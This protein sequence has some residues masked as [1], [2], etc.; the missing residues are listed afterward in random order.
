MSKY[1]VTS[2]IFIGAFII[3]YCLY[4]FLM[5]DNLIL[6][7]ANHNIQIEGITLLQN[8]DE[9]IKKLGIGEMSKG[10]TT[11][12]RY[13]YKDM[14]LSVS[15]VDKRVVQLK[16]QNSKHSILGISAGISY[17]DAMKILDKEG[18]KQIHDTMF[19]KGE[20]YIQLE[21]NE[22]IILSVSIWYLDRKHKNRSY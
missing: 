18:Y 2:V 14:D 9:V 12:Y 22:S 13:E 10:T 1:K 6:R 15:F 16:T 20:V 17:P 7:H 5:R 4:H 8:E 3:S 11:G 19:N 21:E